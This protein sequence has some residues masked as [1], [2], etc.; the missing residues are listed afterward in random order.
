MY[1]RLS[2]GICLLFFGL[3]GHAQDAAPVDDWQPAVTNQNGKEYPQVNSEGRVKFRVHA[4][5]AKSVSCTFRDSSEFVKDDEGYWTGYTRKLDEGF[6][7]YELVIDGAKV[8]D[9]NSKYFFGAMR[10]GSGVEV[11][12][13][14]KDF[15]ALKKVPHGHLREVL[16][17]SE[18]TQ[19]DRRAFVYTPPGYDNDQEKRYPVLYLQHGWG[20]NEYGWSVQGHA[21][22]IMDN[23]IAEGK[24]TP[25][26]V[27]M[28]Y[29]MTNDTPMGGLRN[30]DITHFET[31][32]VKELIPYVDANF[33]TLTDQPNRAMAGL[34][35]GGMETK[36]ITLRNLDLFSHIG[37]FSGGTITLEDANN[38]EGFKEK[39]QLVFVS[40]G[41]KEVGGGGPRR[42]GDPEANAQALK[43]AGINSHYY[44]SPDTAHEWQT[45]RRSLREM[46]PLLFV[47][48]A[49]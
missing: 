26:I 38:T 32:L 40:Y 20:E 19:T 18:S 47:P 11:P 25:F 22:L 10:W 41:S 13:K 48:A 24:V 34:S 1:L 43:E 16:F 46:A 30:F 7:Y 36:L 29:G 21:G 44:V 8:P 31:V 45:W 28:T 14:D 37:L 49:N 6:H 42:G 5:D 2:L 15:Y 3:L 4:P 23:L 12:A 9:P 17:Y 35:M 39:V 33:R 27:V